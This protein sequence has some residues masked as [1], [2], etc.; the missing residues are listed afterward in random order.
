[1]ILIYKEGP[2]VAWLS[3]CDRERKMHKPQ[4]RNGAKDRKERLVLTSPSARSSGTPRR[5]VPA[6]KKQI[7]KEIYKRFVNLAAALCRANED[8]L[9]TGMLNESGRLLLKLTNL[10]KK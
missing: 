7:T 1:M 5:R 9:R 4:S 3:P 10:G 8:G 6:V 2:R